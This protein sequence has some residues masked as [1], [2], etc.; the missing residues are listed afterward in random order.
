[1]LEPLT[2]CQLAMLALILDTEARRYARMGL[3][4]TFKTD[5]ELE[6]KGVVLNY[7]DAKIRIARAGGSNDRYQKTLEAL[8]KPYRR[9]IQT[10]TLDNDTSREILRQ[11][12]ARAVILDWQTKG[13]D[14]EFAKGIEGADGTLLEVNVEN[15]VKTFKALP[16]LFTDVIAQANQVSLF[17]SGDLEADAGNS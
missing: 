8:T 6:K 12:Y 4:K 9:A 3:Y 2:L 10:E 14:G 7:G 1:M 5:D 11:V 13:A 15:I 16:D 17:R